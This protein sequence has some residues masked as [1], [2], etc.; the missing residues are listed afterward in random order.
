MARDRPEAEVDDEED[1][2]IARHIVCREDA[3]VRAGRGNVGPD[4]SGGG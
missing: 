4:G 3:V 1:R 2:P